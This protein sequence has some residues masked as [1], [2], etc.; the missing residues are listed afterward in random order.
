MTDTTDK[1]RNDAIIEDFRST[2]PLN[3]QYAPIPIKF[4]SR[5]GIDVVLRFGFLWSVNARG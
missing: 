5:S 3:D 4:Y 1:A 2:Q